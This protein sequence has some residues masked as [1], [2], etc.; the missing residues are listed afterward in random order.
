MIT[1]QQKPTVEQIEALEQLIAAASLVVQTEGAYD[2]D[3]LAES[4]RELEKA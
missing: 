4:I 2:L 1:A 3:H